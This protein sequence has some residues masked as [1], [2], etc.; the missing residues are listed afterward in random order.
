[1]DISAID[2]LRIIRAAKA[3]SLNTNVFMMK[4]KKCNCGALLFVPFELKKDVQPDGFY[5]IEHDFYGQKIKLK[6]DTVYDECFL[7]GNLESKQVGQMLDAVLNARIESVDGKKLDVNEIGIEIVE[8]LQETIKP[9]L[10]KYRTLSEVEV[11]CDSCQEKS[12]FR[13]SLYEQDF[14]MRK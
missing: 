11:T 8:W 14:V 3:Q 2:A 1:M 13:I 12:T 7:L 9:E 10:E 6:P 4:G 5:E